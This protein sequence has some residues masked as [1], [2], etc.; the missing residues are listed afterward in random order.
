MLATAWE[1]LVD[2]VEHA[3]PEQ[4]TKWFR[5]LSKDGDELGGAFALA[6]AS[7][8]LVL[9]RLARVALLEAVMRADLRDVDMALGEAV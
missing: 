1:E 6:N 4:I 3:D 7:D 5:R 8:R 9:A 2:W